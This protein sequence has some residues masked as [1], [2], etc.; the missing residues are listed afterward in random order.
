MFALL[1]IIVILMFLMTIAALVFCGYLVF[2]LLGASRKQLES[3][4]TQF[5]PIAKAMPGDVAEF[6][7]EYTGDD[8]FET[9]TDLPLFRPKGAPT[10]T[11]AEVAQF[12]TDSSESSIV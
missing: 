9:P 2:V 3:I 6:M 11:P 10:E 8:R 4:E 1:A 7:K 5:E 12:E